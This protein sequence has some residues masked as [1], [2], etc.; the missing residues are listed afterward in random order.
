[1]SKFPSG[2]MTHGK[3]TI[4]T[5]TGQISTNSRLLVF[6]I[7]IKADVNNA[8]IVYIGNRN[9]T[10]GTAH[11]TD[12]MPLEAGDSIFLEFDSLHKVY[13]KASAADQKVFYMA[14]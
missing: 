13:L 9:L 1:M 7:L 4:G 14:I 12:G 11:A 10:A 6:G 8:G 5:S 2:E 3:K